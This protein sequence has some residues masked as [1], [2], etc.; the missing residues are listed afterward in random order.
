MN[1]ARTEFMMLMAEEVRECQVDVLGMCTPL[2]PIYVRSIT[3]CVCLHYLK[4][5]W[6]RLKRA[7][8]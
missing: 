8:K 6:R 3:D 2:S 4:E 7:V 1:S 5:I